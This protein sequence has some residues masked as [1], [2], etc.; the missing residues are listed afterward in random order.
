[1][2]SVL[3]GHNLPWYGHFAYEANEGKCYYR[4]NVKFEN[5]WSKESNYEYGLDGAMT[6]SEIGVYKANKIGLFDI[7]GNVA[8]IT[9]SGVIKGGSWD[10]TI[11]ECVVNKVQDFKLPDPRVGF[12][13]V[14]VIEEL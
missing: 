9:A 8:E 10:N 7:I 6:T 3:P 12:R 1:M 4:A 11:D 13:V 14:M 5:Q 2:A